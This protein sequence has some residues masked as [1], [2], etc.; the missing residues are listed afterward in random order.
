MQDYSPALICFLLFPKLLQLPSQAIL[1]AINISHSATTPWF[2]HGNCYLFK[3]RQVRRW[4][5][6]QKQRRRP[7][8]RWSC[9]KRTPTRKAMTPGTWGKRPPGRGTR[10]DGADVYEAAAPAA[11]SI[12]LQRHLAKPSHCKEKGGRRNPRILQ[13]AG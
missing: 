12:F 5:C 7:R 11:A 13:E 3:Y 6:L 8:K 4:G 2:W 9:H 10:H 1:M